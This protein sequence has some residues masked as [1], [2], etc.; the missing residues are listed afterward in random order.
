MAEARWDDRGAAAV[1]ELEAVL[2]SH[3]AVAHGEVP[4]AFVVLPTSTISS[5]T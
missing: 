3:P 1:A 4:K 5:S 2:V